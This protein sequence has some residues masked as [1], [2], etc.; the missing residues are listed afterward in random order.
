MAG[1][2]TTHPLSLY[3]S[4]YLSMLLGFRYILLYEIVNNYQTT[5]LDV[6]GTLW[7]LH[8]LGWVP[9]AN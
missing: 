1:S 2:R 8:R 4:P 9:G 5:L 3:S 6:K 7:A